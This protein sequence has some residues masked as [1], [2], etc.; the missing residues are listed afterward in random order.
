MLTRYTHGPM[1]EED[2]NRRDG[3]ER[4]GGEPAD[5]PASNDAPLPAVASAV[6]GDG[7]L[8]VV[9]PEEIGRQDADA[10]GA[11]GNGG[12]ALGGGRPPGGLKNGE[13]GGRVGVGGVSAFFYF[14][15]H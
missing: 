8:I 13:V 9:S 1:T 5:A 12:A 14:G 3:E 2:K 10:A 7:G 11:G 15:G 4:W 6:G